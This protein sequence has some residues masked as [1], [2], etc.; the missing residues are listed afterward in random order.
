MKSCR[1]DR[2][3]TGSERLLEYLHQLLYCKSGR[4]S[5]LVLI[6]V[7][8]KEQ[9]MKQGQQLGAV[10]L[11]EVTEALVKIESESR[12]YKNLRIVLETTLINLIYREKNNVK[13]IK[14][15]GQSQT[16]Q[17]AESTVKRK[18][19]VRPEKVQEEEVI[20]QAPVVAFAQV[21]WPGYGIIN[22]SKVYSL[23]MN[24]SLMK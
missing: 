22:N 12:W 21:K 6:Q 3:G 13:A 9:M 19:P 15:G 11:T 24:V 23:L 17:L 1:K 4:E 16:R 20:L 2:A 10:W 14:T 18:K 8:E 5:N 7:Q